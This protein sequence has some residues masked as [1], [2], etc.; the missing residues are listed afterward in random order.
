MI[1]FANAEDMVVGH[2]NYF[3]RSVQE[4]QRSGDLRFGYY[5]G[6]HG[7]VFIA[8]EYMEAHPHNYVWSGFRSAD[9][10]DDLKITQAS[11]WILDGDGLMAYRAVP[12]LMGNVVANNAMSALEGGDVLSTENLICDWRYINNG[13]V[14][15]DDSA[16]DTLRSVYRAASDVG[17]EQ[18]R[19]IS[20]MSRFMA[21]HREYNRNAVQHLADLDQLDP[22]KQAL[23]A[24]QQ[25]LGDVQ[26]VDGGYFVPKDSQ[27]ILAL[28][29]GG[30]ELQFDAARNGYFIPQSQAASV[31]NVNRQARFNL[32][33][34]FNLC[35]NTVE[36]VNWGDID[37]VGYETPS[38]VFI[39]P[40]RAN[41]LINYYGY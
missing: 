40:E 31:V 3:Q 15:I 33:P 12:T 20:L 19:D 1:S 8:P 29:E 28:Q 9:R 4:L 32:D 36:E 34:D 21:R 2:N 17:Q 39:T 16:T 22:S 5:P 10:I 26:Y 6:E 23:R 27:A 41:E 38:D 14:H 25:A 7:N 24:S 35:F 11:N 13:R 37:I 30:V 18:L